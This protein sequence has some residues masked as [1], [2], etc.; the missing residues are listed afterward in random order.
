MFCLVSWPQDFSQERDLPP[1]PVSSAA[2][3]IVEKII[4]HPSAAP[5]STVQISSLDLINKI[6][7]GG[8][9]N[10]QNFI[11]IL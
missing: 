2:S 7:S 4:E 6:A 1:T 5:K 11:I 8:Q 10:N 3:V 9:G